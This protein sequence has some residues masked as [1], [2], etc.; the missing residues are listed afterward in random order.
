MYIC[1]FITPSF[2][3]TE[4]LMFKMSHGHGKGL[5][6]NFGLVRQLNIGQAN[7]PGRRPESI[8]LQNLPIMCFLSFP[9]FFAYCANFYSMLP[10]YAE[11][12]S[13]KTIIMGD[14]RHAGIML[15]NNDK[16]KELRILM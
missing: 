14:Y 15:G 2:E 4:P 9:K 1:L 7:V 16:A 13:K 3:T 10:N 6:S 8:M 11:N 12:W 5:G